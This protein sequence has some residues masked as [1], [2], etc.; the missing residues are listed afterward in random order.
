MKP[1]AKP[2]PQFRGA[3]VD[4]VIDVRTRIE[5]WLGHLPGAECIPVDQMPDAIAGR[6]DLSETT[7]ILVYCASGNRS[8]AAD[9][10]LKAAGYRNVVDAG[11]IGVATE[12]FTS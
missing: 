7:R 8:A 1:A 9:A 6:A 11:G 2:A 3:P 12:H 4:I 5:F 10:R